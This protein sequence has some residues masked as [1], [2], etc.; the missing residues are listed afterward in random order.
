[1]L[2]L[3]YYFVEGLMTNDSKI[4]RKWAIMIEPAKKEFKSSLSKKTA[5]FE[6]HY[7]RKQY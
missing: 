2:L 6:N 7:C 4:L 3:E 1:M 5:D